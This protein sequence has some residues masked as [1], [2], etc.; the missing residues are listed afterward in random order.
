MFDPNRVHLDEAKRYP[1]LFRSDTI[2]DDFPGSIKKVWKCPKCGCIHAFDKK[3][4]R[5]KSYHQSDAADLG[6][7]LYE[8]LVFND[9]TWEKITDKSLPNK[10][11]IN[12][13]PN[14][15]LKVY[16]K[17]MIVSEKKPFSDCRVYEL[18]K[19]DTDE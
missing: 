17:G 12:Q 7:L 11:L 10:E 1:K 13:K 8:G 6:E 5:I 16:E 9:Y 19:T 2:E 15:F 3:G 18:G 14:A 4:K